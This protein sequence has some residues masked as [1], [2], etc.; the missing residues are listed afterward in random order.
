M[1]EYVLIRSY[2]SGVHIGELEE[3]DRLTRHAVLKNTRRIY[4]WSGAAT[5]SQLAL[6]G[7]KNP[8]SCKFTVEIPKIT[9]A[10]VIEMIPVSSL[11][12]ENIAGV[13]VWKM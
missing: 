13:K 11:A 12:R 6:E 2:S 1:M 10:E 3:Y 9:I 5:L 7:T 8:E 4:Y